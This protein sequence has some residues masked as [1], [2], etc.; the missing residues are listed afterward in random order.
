MD[1][2]FATHSHEHN[3]FLNCNRQVIRF[4]YCSCT[5]PWSLV[6]LR[7]TAHVACFPL[8][9]G[10]ARM[11]RPGHLSHLHPVA[12]A[13]SSLQRAALNIEWSARVLLKSSACYLNAAEVDHPKPHGFEFHNILL[14]DE[15]E[16]N[17]ARDVECH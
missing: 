14:E 4:F 12:Q 9:N 11:N 3:S 10:T 17:V 7:Y 2:S 15:Y 8:Y 5:K 1:T 16:K 13:G 6:R